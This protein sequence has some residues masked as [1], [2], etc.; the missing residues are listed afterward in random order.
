MEQLQEE[1]FTE[2]DNF[3]PK[4]QRHGYQE[5][6]NDSK[7]WYRGIYKNGFDVGYQEHNPYGNYG[8]GEYG[9][10]VQFYIR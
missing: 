3:N 7:V 5:W 2:I 9:T 8:I 6:C 10:I 1:E 4:G